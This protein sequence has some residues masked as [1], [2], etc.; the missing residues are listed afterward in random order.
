MIPRREEKLWSAIA[1][2]A[3]G[4]YEH[5]GYYP[6]QMWIYKFLA[7]LDFAL[8]KKHGAPCLGLEYDALPYGPVPMEIYNACHFQHLIN[9]MV[10]FVKTVDGGYRVEACGEPN[11]DLFS[12]DELDEMDKI[13][14]TYTKDGVNLD[15]LIKSA[16]EKIRAWREAW[17]KAKKLDRKKF[18][19]DYADEFQESP[20]NKPEDELTPE[21]ARFLCYRDVFNIENSSMEDVDSKFVAVE[22]ECR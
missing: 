15:E 17:N 9:E 3:A 5:R 10:D 13:L 21:E 22:D 8:L 19:M 12:D 18:P 14:D 6:R 7:L 20:L 16:H 4:F 11:L 2:F 1:Y